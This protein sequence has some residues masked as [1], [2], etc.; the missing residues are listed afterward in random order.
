[1][2][3]MPATPLRSPATIGQI[4]HGAPM[5]RLLPATKP[6]RMPCQPELAE[7]HSSTNSLGRISGKIAPIIKPRNIFGRISRNRTPAFPAVAS[8]IE[9][10]F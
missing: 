6:R 9:A 3:P 7:S 5:G 10:D 8:G 1:M 4:T 2:G